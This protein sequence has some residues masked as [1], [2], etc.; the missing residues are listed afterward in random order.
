MSCIILIYMLQ[1][2]QQVSYDGQLVLALPQPLF[3]KRRDAVW[4]SY[5]LQI[6]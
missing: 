2:L 1:K 6:K 4:V 5:R 3:H